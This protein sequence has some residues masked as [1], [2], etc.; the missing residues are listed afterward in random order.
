LTEREQERKALARELH[1]QVIQDLLSRNYQLEEIE[2]AAE[3]PERA[4]DLADVRD[5]IR[6][7]VDDVRRI[8]GNLRPPTIDSLG[9]ARR[10]NP[11]PATG[12]R[13]RAAG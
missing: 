5:S 8:C 12:R 6:A 1:D 2:V 13:A 9:W 11:T 7:L 4:D 10:S 3:Q